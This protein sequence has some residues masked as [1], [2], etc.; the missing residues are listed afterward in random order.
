MLFVHSIIF[1][2]AE[3]K[4]AIFQ[5][6]SVTLVSLLRY[7]AHGLLKISSCSF[8]VAFHEPYLT[9]QSDMTCLIALFKLRVVFFCQ[10][11]VV[12]S[13]SH[14]RLCHCEWFSHRTPDF[15]Y[16][17]GRLSKQKPPSVNKS[18]IVL[19]KLHL[20]TTM[21]VSAPTPKLNNSVA[22]AIQTGTAV[23]YLIRSI[24]KLA[25]TSDKGTAL[26]SFL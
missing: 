22:E 6:V 14:H 24:A 7:S 19:A 1:Q 8:I 20:S 4:T 26:I 23:S 21:K 3:I 13:T 2:K 17:A 9:T 25:D 18:Q 11:D 15:S 5:Y 16:H 10:F 12:F